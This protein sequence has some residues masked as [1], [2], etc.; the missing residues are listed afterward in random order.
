M[1]KRLFCVILLLVF[2]VALTPTAS[3]ATYDADAAI[4]YAAAHWN[5]GVGVCDQFLKACLSAGGV[6]IKSGGSNSVYNE[7]KSYGNSYK[8]TMSGYCVYASQ[9]EGK[10]AVGDPLF[11]YCNICGC[12]MHSAICGAI[13]SQ[14]R[15]CAYGHNSAWNNLN[16]IGRFYDAYGHANFSIYSIRMSGSL[17]ATKAPVPPA[18]VR[19]TTDKD[20]Y[21]LGETVTITP[22]AANAAK[23]TIAIALDGE[24]VFS[25]QDGF[26]GSVT[27]TPEQAGAYEVTLTAVNSGGSATAK[28]SFRVAMTEL[29]TGV[30]VETDSNVYSLGDTVKITP[31][32]FNVDKYTIIIS[33]DGSTVST[34]THDPGSSKTYTP[35]QAGEYSVLV[36]GSNAFGVE[37]AACTFTVT[38]DSAEVH[39]D[40]VNEYTDGQF[41][42]VS[43]VHWFS[44]YVAEVYERGLMKGSSATTFNPNGNLTVAEAVTMAARI[45]SIYCFGGEDFPQTSGQAWYQVYLDYAYKNGIISAAIYESDVRQK[46]T[47]GQFAEIFAHALPDQAL[48]PVNEVAAG[49]I[50]DVKDS[51]SYGE[52][53]Y[54][55]YRAGIFGGY[56][57]AGTFSPDSYLTRAQAAA[58]AARMT[59]SDSRLSFTMK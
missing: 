45:H 33:Y 53:V 47:R 34:T 41:D 35:R 11:Y 30:T 12:V 49:S 55:L 4:K 56:D 7:L 15:V 10:V 28:G 32:G 31:S 58:A 43:D 52:A 37:E 57:A 20:E 2:L 51:A 14:G 5:D 18:D 48:Y 54:K 21:Y 16:E 42:D 9:N 44:S 19:V 6:T 46:T 8:L 23:Y 26:T 36:K 40:S 24:T 50:P 3:A 25:N 22:S 1:K 38:A 13:D 29:P 39:F 17:G 59:E 27:Y